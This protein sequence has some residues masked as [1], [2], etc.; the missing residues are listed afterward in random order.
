[1]NLEL[2][3]DGYPTENTLKQI[4]KYRGNP[5]LLM[6][7]I[8]FLFEP[9]GSCQKEGNVWQVSTGGWSGCESIIATLEMNFIFWWQCWKLTMRGG[10]YEFEMP[11]KPSK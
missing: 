4:E 3:D 8:K 9:Y 5:D 2:D 10:Y 11:E 1:M 7:E 6:Q